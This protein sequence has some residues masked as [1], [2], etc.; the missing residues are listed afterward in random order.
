MMERPGES[1]EE[2]SVEEAPEGDPTQSDMKDLEDSDDTP[3]DGD[4]E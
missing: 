3:F 2:G 4:E 1:I